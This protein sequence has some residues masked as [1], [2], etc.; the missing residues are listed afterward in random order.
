MISFY[1]M[2]MYPL[3]K[4]GLYN[5]RSKLLKEVSGDVLEIGAGTG[6]NLNHYN[7][8]NIKSLIVTDKKVK[9][10]LKENDKEKVSIIELNAELLPF[11]DQTFDYIVHTLVFCSIINRQ[12]AMNELK[13]ILKDDGNLIFIEHVLPIRPFYKGLFKT[14]NPVWKHV[15]GGCHLDH[16]YEKTLK[17]AG[18]KVERK[19]RFFNSTFIS[20]IA[21]KM[22][23]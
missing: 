18:F 7:I 9:K 2:F 23:D 8:E 13:R 1:N 11:A 20:G 4:S 21:S 10:L 14:I 3:E 5:K 19:S 22:D 6:V 12:K 15:S 16:D 17:N